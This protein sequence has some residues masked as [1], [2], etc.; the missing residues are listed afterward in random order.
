MRFLGRTLAVFGGVASA[1]VLSALFGIHWL[2]SPMGMAAG[3]WLGHWVVFDRRS[4]AVM[5]REA[6]ERSHAFIPAASSSASVLASN[7][8]PPRSIA[9]AMLLPSSTPNWS[10]GLI[11]IRTALAKVRCS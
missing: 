5:Q 8:S 10:N 6:E 4:P 1:I 9:L 7:R 2:S 11:P 3:G